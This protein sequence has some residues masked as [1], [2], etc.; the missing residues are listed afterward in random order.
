MRWGEYETTEN[1][2]EAAAIAASFRTVA[3]SA[4]CIETGSKAGGQTEEAK[5]ILQ[6]LLEEIKDIQRDRKR[7]AE[8]IDRQLSEVERG[9][10][11]FIATDAHTTLPF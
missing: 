6:Q 7:Y 3:E 5:G 11:D 1:I 2:E 4:G 10:Y 9:I 8:I